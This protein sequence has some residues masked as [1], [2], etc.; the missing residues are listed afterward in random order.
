MPIVGQVWHQA[1]RRERRILCG[2]WLNCTPPWPSLALPVLGKIELYSAGNYIQ[3]SVTDYNGK[4][5]EKECV[6]MC[7]FVFWITLLDSKNQY[8]FI[9]LPWVCVHAK[10]LQPC[11]TVCDP[12]DCSP[13]VSSVHGDSPGKNTGVGCHALFQ[14]IFPT[15]GSI[16]HLFKSPAL[17]GELFTTRATWEA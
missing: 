13:P 3:Y 9:N 1:M 17:A 14:G 12:M 6:Y 2:S 4:E 10:L 8:N 15:Q 7:V 5:C 11:P 16:P